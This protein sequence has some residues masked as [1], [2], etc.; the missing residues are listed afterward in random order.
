MERFLVR[1]EAFWKEMPSKGDIAAIPETIE[2]YSQL[3]GKAAFVWIVEYASENLPFVFTDTEDDGGR[4]LDFSGLM[5]HEYRGLK[6]ALMEKLKLARKENPE[7]ARALQ[8]NNL[9]MSQMT[10]SD[11]EGSDLDVP[12]ARVV[13][14]EEKKLKQGT[15][16]NGSDKTQSN[17]RPASKATRPGPV[18][19]VHGNRKPKYQSK[20]NVDRSSKPSSS[21]SYSTT[22]VAGLNPELDIKRARGHEISTAGDN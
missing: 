17:R 8:E 5:P 15:E 20:S 11:T 18:A 12:L 19:K 14:Q 21:S 6:K 3:V 4:E 2:H 16:K 13:S 7:K 10:M 22:A 9:D 1:H